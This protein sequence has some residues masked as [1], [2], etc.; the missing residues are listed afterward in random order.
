MSYTCPGAEL[1]LTRASASTGCP[2]ASPFLAGIFAYVGSVA[3]VAIVEGREKRFIKGAFSKH[4]SP[5]L[6]E[7]LAENPALLELGGVSRPITLLFSDLAGFTTLSE[8]MTPE[9]LITL[10]NEYLDDMTEIVVSEEG[11]PRQVHR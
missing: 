9:D 2:V 7:Q 10:L 11:L 3:Y 1:V 4:V 5:T 8:K 6:A